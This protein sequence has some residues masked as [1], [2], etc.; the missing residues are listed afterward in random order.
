MM[1]LTSAEQDVQVVSDGGSVLVNLHPHISVL[2][3]CH[4]WITQ[5]CDQNGHRQVYGIDIF[6]GEVSV[7][8]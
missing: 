4:I 1:L 5:I 2:L 3:F 7:E 8:R 6:V